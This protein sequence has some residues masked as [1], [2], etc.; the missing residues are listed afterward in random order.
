MQTPPTVP[1]L[2]E[3]ERELRSMSSE[4]GGFSEVITYLQTS[5]DQLG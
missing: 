1:R 5:I 4:E 3:R 2:L